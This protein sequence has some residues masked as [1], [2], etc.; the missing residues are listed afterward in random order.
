MQQ[1]GDRSDAE[2]DR[3]R[4]ALL[5]HTVTEPCADIDMLDTS[6]DLSGSFMRRGR[7]GALPSLP[8][9]SGRCSSIASSRCSSVYSRDGSA[10]SERGSRAP[11]ITS[12]RRSSKRSEASGSFH[13]W[14]SM[15]TSPSFKASIWDAVDGDDDKAPEVEMIED[16]AQQPGLPRLESTALPSLT[17]VAWQDPQEADLDKCRMAFSPGAEH[18]SKTKADP[19]DSKADPF[20][21]PA[22]DS[23]PQSRL[24][25]WDGASFHTA[26]DDDRTSIFN[27]LEGVGKDP[28]SDLTVSSGGSSKIPTPPSGLRKAHAAPRP[29]GQRKLPPVSLEAADAALSA[30]L[31]DTLSP[32]A[33]SG[34]SS[35]SGAPAA[36]QIKEAWMAPSEPQAPPP[37]SRFIRPGLRPLTLPRAGTGEATLDDESVQT[38][39]SL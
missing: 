16:H 33:C 30:A 17:G 19:F 24:S 37:T 34:R 7:P 5:W 27:V 18:P 35:G 39:L 1:K 3:S 8:P 29:K 25:D 31:D 21:F 4:Q 32:S 26:I 11:S 9:G 13:S 22:F 10:R 14:H 28:F 12:N 15:P 6:D 2:A 38:K 20:D 36:P 23:R